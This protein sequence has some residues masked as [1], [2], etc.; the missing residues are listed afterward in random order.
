MR[1]LRALT[2]LEWQTR[3][4]NQAVQP[5]LILRSAIVPFN[6]SS[7]SASALNVPS[8]H[9][10]KYLMSVQFNL[11]VSILC[12][13]PVRFLDHAGESLIEHPF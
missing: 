5:L 7:K 9:S 8:I 3:R 6:S 13:Q 11:F 4:A 2:W 12:C 10:N 1:L